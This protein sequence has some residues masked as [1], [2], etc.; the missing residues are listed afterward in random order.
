[1]MAKY[2]FHNFKEGNKLYKSLRDLI[3]ENCFYSA[4]RYF[5]SEAPFQLEDILISGSFSEGM[6]NVALK[7]E[8]ASDIDFMLVLKNIEVSEEE[9]QKGNLMTKENTPFVTVYLNPVFH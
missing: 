5:D 8:S 2:Q 9:Q 4:N 6:Q 7:K 3:D 1:M